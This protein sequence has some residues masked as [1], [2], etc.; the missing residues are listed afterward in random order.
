MNV[1]LSGL[2]KNASDCIEGLLAVIKDRVGEDEFDDI[3]VEH[4]PEFYAYCLQELAGH[5]RET[6]QGKHTA[7]EFIEF[8]DL[9]CSNIVATETNHQSEG[10]E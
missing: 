9:K 1:S 7:E 3:C 8:Y 6:N 5:A 2:C 10:A 4:Q